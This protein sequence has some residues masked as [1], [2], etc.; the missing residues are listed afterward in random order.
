MSYY[1]FMMGEEFKSQCD[2]PNRIRDRERIESIHGLLEEG[3]DRAT[4]CTKK[5]TLI[6]KGYL[7]VVYGDHGPYVE[8]LPRHMVREAWK[9]VRKGVGWYDICQPKDGSYCKL[10]VQTKS[11]A[12]LKNPPKGKYSHNNNR[13][14]GYADYKVGRLYISPDD[15]FIMP[16]EI[17]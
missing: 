7:R 16:K 1:K 2:T 17:A 14:E 5:G 9:T 15:M 6:A 10:Y 8:F 13:Q 12:T 3:D 4:F 11:V